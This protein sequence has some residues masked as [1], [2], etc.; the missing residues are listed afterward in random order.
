[1][2]NIL[3]PLILVILGYLL[4]RVHIV[5]QEIA[6]SLIRLVFYVFLP[7]TL[8]YSISGL[9]LKSTMLILPIAGF[10][11]ALLCYLF[12]F[13]IKDYLSIERKTQGSF[14]IACGATNQGMFAYPF[15]FMYLGTKGLSYVA[16][17]D[18]GQA[19]LCLTLGYYIAIKFGSVSSGFKSELRRSINN[20]LTFPVLW[21]FSLSLLMNYLRLYPSIQPVFPLIEILHNCTVPLIMLSLGIF[22]ELR[23]KES[24]AMLSAIFTRFVLGFLFAFLLVSILNLQGLERITLL[25]ASAV[26]PAMITLVYSVEERLDVEFTVALLSVCICIGLI[27][28]PL[29]FT[30]LM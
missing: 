10:L 30:F 26:P 28:T 20:M 13:F 22:L 23:I 11:V 19:I 27:Y 14:L 21:A 6:N 18:I 4:K 24:K 12:G 5:E 25:I 29:L 15:F 1:M 8:F 16:F 3:S 7:A 17:Y 2:I 9:E